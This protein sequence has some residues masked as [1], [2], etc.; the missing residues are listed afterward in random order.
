MD[1]TCKIILLIISTLFSQLNA[2]EQFFIYPDPVLPDSLPGIFAPGLISLPD[3]HEEGLAFS[4]DGKEIFF[5]RILTDEDDVSQSIIFCLKKSGNSW[6][7]VKQAPFTS[8]TNDSEPAFGKDGKQLY[9]FSERRK[10]GIT[11]YIGEIWISEKYSKGWG[12]ATYSEDILNEAWINSVSST[13]NGRLYFSSFRS[14][15]IGIFYSDIHGG[16]Y[17][18]PVYLPKEINSIAG[19]TNPFIAPNDSILVFEGKSKGYQHSE[20]YISFKT[21]EGI[22]EPAHKLNEKINL[23]KTETNPSLSP[24]GK[25]LFF[26]RNGDIYWVR[27]EYI[28]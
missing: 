23:T 11:P 13:I 24:D 21:T 28:F 3:N 10:P 25:Y 1:K 7:L 26:T 19:A 27:I 9:F 15:Q 2:Q 17:Q 14:N 5:T 4:P 12:K 18:E 6:S 22:W 8:E 20:L 16:E